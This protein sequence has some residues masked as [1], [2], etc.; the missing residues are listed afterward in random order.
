MPLDRCRFA[1]QEAHDYLARKGM[2]AVRRAFDVGVTRYWG[3][4]VKC[5]RVLLPSD[6]WPELVSSDA[7]EH[8]LVEVMNQCATM[9]RLLDALEWAQGAESML[10]ESLVERCHP[11]TSSSY[12]DEDDHDLV[13]VG[14]DGTKAKFEISDVSGAKDGNNK[15][16][17]DLISLGVLRQGKGKEVF[18]N[19]WP[20]GRLFLV[21]SEEFASRLRKPGR[22]WLKGTPP[23]CH[24]NELTAH[25]KTRIF[26]VGKGAKL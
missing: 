10:N 13:L 1:V 6:E 23:H 19:E 11:T 8:N 25:G 26:E 15:E 3:T 5:V 4:E 17:K 21:V 22:A 14:P 24:Y 16:K 20:K 2:E 7:E 18:P 9:E 12:S